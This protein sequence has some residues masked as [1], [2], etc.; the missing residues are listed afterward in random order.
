MPV[1]QA[2]LLYAVD[3]YGV[4]RDEVFKWLA[5]PYW[6]AADRVRQA[7]A[8]IARDLKNSENI[9]PLMS[10]F[11][12]TFSNAYFKINRVDR[13]I[14]AMQCVEAIRMHAAAHAGGVPATLDEITITPI[15]LD[16]ITGKNFN[17]KV[18]G[19][20]IVLEGP[21]PTPESPRDGLRYEITLV[22]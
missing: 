6:Q 5:L 17:Y 9:N 11:L 3:Q 4:W 19:E 1:Q 7:E 12:P 21:P 14:A 22:K 2:I 13:L 18:D 15:P 10:I 8:T 20:R 16:P